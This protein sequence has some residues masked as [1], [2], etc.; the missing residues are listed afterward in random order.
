MAKGMSPTEKAI[1]ALQRDMASVQTSLASR[2]EAPPV[3]PVVSGPPQSPPVGWTRADRIA[4][5]TLVASLLA[6]TVAVVALLAGYYQW[7]LPLHE[8]KCGFLLKPISIPG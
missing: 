6:F 8:Q 7:W 4:L 2:N 3:Q 1:A 5:A